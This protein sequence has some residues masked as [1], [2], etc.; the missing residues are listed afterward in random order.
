[1]NKAVYIPSEPEEILHRSQVPHNIIH[2]VLG[3]YQFGLVCRNAVDPDTNQIVIIDSTP[4][5]KPDAEPKRFAVYR[6]HSQV[7]WRLAVADGSQLNKFSDYTCTTQIHPKLQLFIESQY[8]N[9]AVVDEADPIINARKY[10]ME[11][12]YRLITGTGAAVRYSEMITT[13]ESA[14]DTKRRTMDPNFLL[15]S[16]QILEM[17]TTTS[18]RLKQLIE[19]AKSLIGDRAYPVLLEDCEK[20]L[21]KGANGAFKDL[22]MAEKIRIVDRYLEDKLEVIANNT[23][24]EYYI[25]P[26]TCLLSVLNHEENLDRE[27]DKTNLFKNFDTTFPTWLDL[28][29]PN[30]SR[31]RN[32]KPEVRQVIT[33]FDRSPAVLSVGLRAKTGPAET[34]RLYYFDYRY[35]G[36]R[37]M[38]PLNIVL[39]GVDIDM[40]G[41]PHSY[42]PLGIYA[43]KIMDYLQQVDIYEGRK[44]DMYFADHRR[45]YVFTGALYT[46]L[47]PL[48]IVPKLKHLEILEASVPT[49]YNPMLETMVGSMMM[50]E[51]HHRMYNLPANTNLRR[52]A[53]RIIRSNKG[54]S[55]RKSLVRSGTRKRRSSQATKSVA[56]NYASMSNTS[57]SE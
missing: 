4:I 14:V 52:A 27:A 36:K 54:G 46:K 19:K 12:Y 41:M 11:Y 32:N 8:D 18:A 30:I 35:R 26:A 6:S 55:R 44:Y 38:I 1:M 49:A 3:S 33:L 2:T 37:Y 20:Y 34:Y 42:I 17:G 28:S 51:H 45:V 53:R 43:G 9:I 31:Q 40:L 7:Q 25:D 21:P 57:E 15:L 39:D 48:A 29:A 5:N 22:T 50:P 10:D 13:V 24:L 16:T 23:K 56:N 47:W